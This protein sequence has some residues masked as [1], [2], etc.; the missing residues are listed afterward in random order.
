M[1]L[2]FLHPCHTEEALPSTHLSR[3]TDAVCVYH[4]YSM[5]ADLDAWSRN[6]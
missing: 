5:R 3:E 6:I 2:M 1:N 4:Y